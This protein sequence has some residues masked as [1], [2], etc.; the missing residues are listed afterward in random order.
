[1]ADTWRLPSAIDR[2]NLVYQQGGFRGLYDEY[3]PAAK[4]GILDAFTYA[5]DPANSDEVRKMVF[6]NTL[7]FDPTGDVNPADLGLMGMFGAMTA[8]KVGKG[9]KA[10]KGVNAAIPARAPA[11]SL[12]TTNWNRGPSVPK[13]F[14][15]QV[16]GANS[17]RRRNWSPDGEKAQTRDAIRQVQSVRS[18][19]RQGVDPLIIN[20]N[21]RPKKAEAI[22]AEARAASAV[23]DNWS[24]K[25]SENVVRDIKGGWDASNS[26]NR[27]NMES[28]PRLLK[29]DGWSVRHA[30]TGKTG[31]KSSRY[32]VSPD[33]QFEVRLSDH[34][35]PQTAQRDFNKAQNGT[36]W[37]DEIVLS[38]SERPIQ[39]LDEIISLWKEGVD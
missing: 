5:G 35:L 3:T 4:Q 31:H 38:G 26:I 20:K 2:A 33:G 18:D 37:N 11:G 29:K 32:L 13:E 27:A 25:F 14:Y 36:R 22:R 12:A 15:E 23:D 24:A 16:M 21:F 28:V 6:E 10:A 30:S 34:Y 39:I 1:M 8:G 17:K 19:T 9:V 7:G